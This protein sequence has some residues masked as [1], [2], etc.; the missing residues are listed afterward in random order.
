M[1]DTHPLAA[2]LR[3]A[4]SLQDADLSADCPSQLVI[5][6]GDGAIGEFCVAAER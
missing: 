1:C 3:F 5:R 4:E 6:A 2:R